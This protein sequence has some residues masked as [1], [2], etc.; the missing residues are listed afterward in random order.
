MFFAVTYMIG[1][2]KF[3]KKEASEIQNQ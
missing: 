1:V 3:F 2:M